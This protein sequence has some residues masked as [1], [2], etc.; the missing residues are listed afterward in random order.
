M[1]LGLYLQMEWKACEHCKRP[2]QVDTVFDGNYTH[3][4][5]PMWHKAGVYDALYDSDNIKAN[6]LVEILEK[7]LV[8]MRDNPQEYI[9]LNP[10]NEW[11]NYDGAVNFL[12]KFLVACKKYPEAIVSV[13][14]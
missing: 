11:G 4:I 1:S 13:W 12:R 2:T 7:G 6:N 9:P 3:N 8:H 14:K 10:A 5:T